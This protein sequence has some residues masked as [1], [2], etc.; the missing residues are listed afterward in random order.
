[1]VSCSLLTVQRVKLVGP[2]FR[3]AALSL[4]S[5]GIDNSPS[6]LLL[7]SWFRVTLQEASLSGLRWVC[8]AYCLH[9]TWAYPAVDNSGAEPLLSRSFRCCQDWCGVDYSDWL[10]TFQRLVVFSSECCRKIY[11]YNI[12]KIYLLYDFVQI[13]TSLTTSNSPWFSW[14]CSHFSWPVLPWL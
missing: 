8:G 2:S 3:L 1:M 11:F 13:V 12:H 9:H 10:S 14:S 6:L 4:S 7:Q 5:H